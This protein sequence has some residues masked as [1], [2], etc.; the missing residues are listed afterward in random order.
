[1]RARREVVL[2]RIQSLSAEKLESESVPRQAGVQYE[3]INDQSEITSTNAA[4]AHI[5]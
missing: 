5:A 3:F 1:M 4:Q 2:N